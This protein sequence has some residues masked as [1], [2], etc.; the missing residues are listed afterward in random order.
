M[1]EL[2]RPKENVAE[3]IQEWDTGRGNLSS[4]CPKENNTK[5]SS[6]KLKT[7]GKMEGKKKIPSIW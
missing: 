2:L 7:K 5:Y 4:I 3:K 6:L 1:L